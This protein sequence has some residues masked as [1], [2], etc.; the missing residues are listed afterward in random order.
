MYTQEMTQENVEKTVFKDTG[1]TI[2]TR[3]GEITFAAQ[4]VVEFPNGLLGMPGQ[5]SFAVA[6]MPLEKFKNF[7]V[8][9]SLVDE[10]TSF[11]LYPHDLMKTKIDPQDVSEICQILE[12]NEDDLIVML[13]A[14]IQR[15]AS[16]SMLTVN[17]RAPIFI[18]VEKQQGYQIVMTS[19]K[20]Q[21][22]HPLHQ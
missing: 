22:Q 13:I 19:N 4:G 9:Q 7:Q 8:M 14:S 11:A 12:F 1:N 17:L 15:T 20:Y 5:T 2:Q 21:V 10:E 3:F 16:K 18:D 6:E